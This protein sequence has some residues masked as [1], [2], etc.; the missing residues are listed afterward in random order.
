MVQKKKQ[1]KRN[2]KTVQKLSAAPSGKPSHKTC[3]AVQTQ[4]QKK[5]QKRK[6]RMIGKRRLYVAAKKGKPRTRHAAARTGNVQYPQKRTAEKCQRTDDRSINKV[7]QQDVSFLIGG[8][9][10]TQ[11]TQFHTTIIPNKQR[12]VNYFN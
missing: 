5:R 8:I 9:A 1:C 10:G 12:F 4:P 11:I 2:E 3:I 6:K 7:P